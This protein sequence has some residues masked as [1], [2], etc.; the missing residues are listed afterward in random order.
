MH[1]LRTKIKKSLKKFVVANI[2]FVVCFFLSRDFPDLV[3]PIF[4]GI[5][6]FLL[7]KIIHSDFYEFIFTKKRYS[8]SLIK[9]LFLAFLPFKKTFGPKMGGYVFSI[10]I[11]SIFALIQ[12]EMIIVLFAGIGVCIFVY[13]YKIK[14]SSIYD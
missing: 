11:P 9:F 14:K 4:A 13:L 12:K 10:F 5:T 1:K 6:S 3:I 8:L 2:I 7:L